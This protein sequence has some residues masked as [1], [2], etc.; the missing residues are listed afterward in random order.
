MRKKKKLIII[1]SLLVGIILSIIGIIYLLNT[2]KTKTEELV[3]YKYNFHQGVSYEVHLKENDLFDVL[4]Q[5][6]GGV[7]I[8]NILD[9][10]TVNYITQ[11]QGSNAAKLD[12]QYTL[13]AKVVG[14]STS[15]DSRIDYW[16]KDIPLTTEQFIHKETDSLEEKRS[17]NIKL[18][19]YDAIAKKANKLTGVNISTE[20]VIGML[21]NITATTP[22]GV[23]E[24][25]IDVNLNIPLQE[26][27]IQITKQEIEDNADQITESVTHEI[28]IDA[29]YIGGIVILIVFMICGIVFAIFGI[30]EPNTEEILRDSV[31]KI[32]KNYGSR[33]VALD[34]TP[35]KS[36]LHEYEV[37]SIK[38]LLI[39]SDEIRLPIYY[40]RD[41]DEIVKGYEYCVDINGD[42][43]RYK[44]AIPQS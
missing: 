43:Y 34:S 21:G 13:H 9:H 28:D 2:P 37:Y 26:N 27:L 42:I 30:K 12:M 14:Y 31:K 35:N 25:P 23:L 44:E 17:I 18:K 36:Y 6:E 20:V 38:D 33:M 41:K 5:E 19:E 24:T 15:N 40:V 10:I 4:V 11:F 16:E 1:G 39:L 8:K 29:K 22:H 3:H 7:Y 32:N